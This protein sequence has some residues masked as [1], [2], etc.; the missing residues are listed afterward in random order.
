MTDEQTNAELDKREDLISGKNGFLEINEIEASPNIE[1]L[2]DT[3]PTAF[4][5]AFKAQAR[6]NPNL[7]LTP[8]QNENG[9]WT[10]ATSHQI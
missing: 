3:L 1:A 7:I 6:T 9:E 8:R 5:E 2:L 10:I 4:L